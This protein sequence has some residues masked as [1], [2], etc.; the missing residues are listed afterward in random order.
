LVGI[1]STFQGRV[2]EN[3]DHS[4]YQF[5]LYSPC[6][7]I[8][9]FLGKREARTD[10]TVNTRLWPLVVAVAVTAAACGTAPAGGASGTSLVLR[11]SPPANKTTLKY[12]MSSN[13]DEKMHSSAS[14]AQTVTVATKGNVSEVISPSSGGDHRIAATYQNWTAQIDG[15]SPQP[16]TALNGVTATFV[17]DSYGHV[18]SVQLSPDTTATKQLQSTFTSVEGSLFPQLPKKTLKPGQTWKVDQVV[19]SGGLTAHIPVV[20]TYEGVSNGDAKISVAAT[21]KLNGTSLNGTE[22]MS[23]IFYLLPTS[24]LLDRLNM[25]ESFTGST[26]VTAA[27]SKST[28]VEQVQM[29]VSVSLQRVP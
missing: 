12:A 3:Y 29:K 28:S 6:K 16:E 15:L 23:G 26:T 8:L 7:H 18:L 20:Y 27:G 17:A 4:C 24:H 5:S 2:N 22:T 25:Q 21:A 1:P 11:Y 13:I 10:H 19:T 9:D 14:G